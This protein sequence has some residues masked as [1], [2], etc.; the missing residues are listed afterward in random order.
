[1]Y[2]RTVLIVDDQEINRKLLGNILKDE[3]EIL[4]A[5]NGKN[6]LALIYEH[7][8]IISAVFLDIIMPEMDGY[9]VLKRMGEDEELSMIPVI[10]SSQKDGDE[11]EIK[12]LSLGA[13]DFIAKPYKAEIICHRLSNLIRL[14]ESSTTINRVQ[15][16]QLTGLL[17]K[18]FF[19]N[20]VE[21]VL[22]QNPE[23]KYAILYLGVERF[24]LINDFYGRKKGDQVLK[25]LADVLREFCCKD[26]IYGR[27]GADNFYVLSSRQD[28][29]DEIFAEGLAKVDKCPIDLDI[30]IHCGI[31]KIT[32]ATLEVESMCDRAKM[33]ADSNRGKYDC[34]FS[35]YDDSLRSRIVDEQ[36]IL[37]TMHTALETQ[38]FQVYY[39]PKYDLNSEMIAGAEALVRWVHPEKGLMSPGDFIPIFERNGFITQLDCYVWEVTCKNIRNWLDK[40]YSPVAVSVN[41]SRVDIYNPKLLDI[42]MN[43][44]A[45]Y[46][47]PTRYLHLEITESAYTENPKQ[48]IDVVRKL[49]DVGF[50]IEMDDFGTGYS[51]L[52]ML[53]EMPVDVMKLDMRFIQTEAKAAAGKGI[54]SFIVSLA[55]WMGLAV[56]AEGVETIEQITVLKSMDC[57]YV[58]GFYYAKPMQA[59]QF[60]EKLK[61]VPV[62]EMI[63]TS[64]N[65]SGYKPERKPIRNLKEGRVMLIVDDIE[66]NRASLA[67]AFCE[68]FLIEER[69]NGLE[70]WEYLDENY[71]KVDVV[72]LDLLM[73]VM[74]GFQLLGKIRED[75]RMRDLPVIITSQAERDREHN[76]FVMQANDFISKPYNLDIIIHRVANV[77]G[78]HQLQL[79]KEGLMTE[80]ELKKLPVKEHSTE[81]TMNEKILQSVEELKKYFDMVWLVDPGSTMVYEG[82]EKNNNCGSCFYVWG[83]TARCNDCSSLKAFE[84]HCRV[85]KFEYSEEGLFFVICQYVPYGKNG[86]VIEMV[87]KLEEEYID[88]VFDKE[89]LYL[90]LKG[91]SSPLEHDDLTKVFNR[92]HLDAYLNRYIQGIKRQGKDLGIAMVD[93][94]NLK[95]LNDT[96]G[97]LTGDETLKSVAKLLEENIALSKGDFVSR[98]GGDEFIIVCRDIAP[99]IFK[100]RINA[101]IKLVKYLLD[102]DDSNIELSLSAGCVM[103]SEM[104]QAD[105]KELVNS[106]KSRLSLA[107]KQGR[108][109]VVTANKEEN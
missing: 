79:F 8:S 104:P 31:Y 108:G 52:N 49:R 56:I 63:C 33:A 84:N 83:K 106:A 102:E 89:M 39:Q 72:M 105:G 17:S 9:E 42:L 64:R 15:T 48:I 103:L 77:V 74:D 14:C 97:H 37:S 50:I 30:K 67:V 93:I 24:K 28:F 107:K 86:A 54:L 46:Q 65:A 73:P 13:Q 3:Y 80:E 35:Y 2:R 32:D 68:E 101:V 98:F 87:S 23:K 40:G 22:R 18:E 11:A 58:Q 61:T 91:K 55:K 36:I 95:L 25:Y 12:A 96:K 20:R 94:D 45:K 1:M 75:E 81:L 43:L 60:E 57:N 5:D 44:V 70:A 47:I 88:R 6:A 53:A 78:N 41:V 109:C 92:R 4:Y 99:D 71:K 29:T 34:A 90:N 7:R 100:K 76:T 85:N 16:D 10:V 66:A 19:I 62:T 59:E 69:E 21:D 82:S 26:S 51:S 27:F 38:Q